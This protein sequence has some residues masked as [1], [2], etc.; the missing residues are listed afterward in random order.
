MTS[1]G[2]WEADGVTPERLDPSPA[3]FLRRACSSEGEASRELFIA[4]TKVLGA[5]RT[6]LEFF[7]Q[8]KETGDPKGIIGIDL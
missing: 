3:R 1:D 7:Q 8:D 5:G 6:F 2:C 4:E